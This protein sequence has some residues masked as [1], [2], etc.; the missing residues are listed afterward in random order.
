LIF[1]A[2]LKNISRWKKKTKKP[3]FAEKEGFEERL[4]SPCGEES[5]YKRY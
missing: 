5:F 1:Y 3:F 2:F 4:S